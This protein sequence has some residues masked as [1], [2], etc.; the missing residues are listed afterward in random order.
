MKQVR[1]LAVAR[2]AL[3]DHGSFAEH[4]GVHLGAVTP[5]DRDRCVGPQRLKQVVLNKPTRF[6]NRYR[7]RWILPQ[8]HRQLA[9]VFAALHLDIESERLTREPARQ[10]GQSSNVDALGI[11]KDARKRRRKLLVHPI[12][13]SVAHVVGICVTVV[14]FSIAPHRNVLRHQVPSGNR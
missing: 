1:R 8:D 13:Q 10:C 4:V 14:H 6:E 5:R 7:R 2:H 11:Y 12:P 3:N 9:R